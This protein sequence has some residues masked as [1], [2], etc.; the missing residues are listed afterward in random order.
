MRE[1]VADARDGD[2]PL[3]AILSRSESFAQRRNLDR[4]VTLLDRGVRPARLHQGGLGHR[5]S[6]GLGQ[7][8]EHRQC[9][10]ADGD[11]LP[12]LQQHSAV[13]VQ[14]EGTENMIA[15]RHVAMA[16][17]CAVDKPALRQPSR[18]MAI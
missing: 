9:P 18:T 6:V 14:N 1:A 11:G 16:P 10:A 4:E 15:V 3:L 12:R 8:A 5:T 7:R 13:P 2:N 17:V